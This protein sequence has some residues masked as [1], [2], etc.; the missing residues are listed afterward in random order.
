LILEPLTYKEVITVAKKSKHREIISGIEKA[1]VVFT[2]AMMTA[3][4]AGT[5]LPIEA[6]IKEVVGGFTV[7]T[8]T[9]FFVV[10]VQKAG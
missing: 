1:R 6:E 9:G 3:L 8:V 2:R 10:T 5:A 7:Q 4:E